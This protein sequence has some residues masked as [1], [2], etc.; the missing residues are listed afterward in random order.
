[1]NKKSGVIIISIIVAIQ[2]L[3]PSVMIA[4]SNYREKQ[5]EQKGEEIK[6]AV[7]YIEFLNTYDDV[8]YTKPTIRVGSNEFNSGMYYLGDPGYVVFEKYE[9]GYSFCSVKENK[10]ET[11]IYLKQHD[12]YWDELVYDCEYEVV[13]VDNIPWY[14]YSKENE[15]ENIFDGNCE[16]PQT[17]SYAI[18]KVYKNRCKVVDVYID[19]LKVE[20]VLEKYENGEMD[21]S[22]YQWEYDYDDWFDDEEDDESVTEPELEN[23]D[24]IA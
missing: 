24:D 23:S 10:P 15:K 7:D 13:D 18:L 9:N 21:L 11:D 20:E 12:Y 22:R 6:L 16:G 14:L 19:G 8:G 2:L 4:L 17:E 1:M 5:L 3:V